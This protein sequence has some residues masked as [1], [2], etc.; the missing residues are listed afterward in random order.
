MIKITEKQFR[1]LCRFRYVWPEL[2]KI[3][4]SLRNLYAAACNGE[5]T[6]RQETR[7]A[8]LQAEAEKMAAEFGLTAYHQTDPRGCALYLTGPDCREYTDGISVH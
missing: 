1:V 7:Q 5:L 4:N 6:K 3:S 2:V 8:N